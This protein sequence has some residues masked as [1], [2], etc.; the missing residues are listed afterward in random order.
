[1][2]K[3]YLILILLIGGLSFAQNK[4][5]SKYAETITTEDLKKHLEVLASDKY[6]GRETGEK[7][8]R[9]AAKYLKKVF[10]ELSLE[11][12][13]THRDPFFQEMKLSN[14]DCEEFTIKSGKTSL[15]NGDDFLYMDLMGGGFE[16]EAD[17]EVVFAGFGLESDYE[18]IDVNGKVVMYFT[19][20]PEDK[21]KDEEKIKKEGNSITLMLTDEKLG[22]AKK[23]GA[24]G[25][26]KIDR[27]EEAAKYLFKM[28][29][30]YIS[31]SRM[32]QYTKK[33]KKGQPE[34]NSSLMMLQS[35]V[36]KLLNLKEE[37]I[38]SVL[39]QINEGKNLAGKYKFDIHV[40]AK[41]NNKA[42][43]TENVVAYI[44]GCE[45]KD[46]LIIIEAHYDHLGKKGDKI[47]NG[48]DDN[49][50]GTVA[51]LEIAEAF[52][53]AK[54]NGVL[55][56]RSILFMPVTGEEKGL[57]GSAY[58]TNNPIFPLEN[59]VLTMNMDMLGRTDSTH[60]ENP[61]YVYVYCSDKRE[62]D[63]HNLMIDS[64]KSV[65]SNLAP[66]YKFKGES[67]GF[68]GSDHMSFEMKKVPVLYYYA[69]IHADYHKPTD[70]VEKI[71]F[72][73]FTNITRLVFSTAW[74]L[75]NRENININR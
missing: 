1:M 7:G 4:I 73:N 37:D 9:M 69:G 59:T 43:P 32:G 14:K 50:T 42:V 55:P 49:A 52:A 53:K 26:I 66:E 5:V 19:G 57:L 11:G 71:N 23:H 60:L 25:G 46:E 22:I 17:F 48:A 28:L 45:L 58:Y 21:N 27:D 38:S 64:E 68:G 35:S 29:G 30:P 67:Q 34:L 70:T 63:L 61:D 51:I 6:E 20:E 36:A 8:Q 39:E 12:P 2:K 56:K 62:S 24:V 10:K 47:Y 41:Y 72:K 75:A 54:A 33:V 65:S 74:E 18:N 31:G 44:E 3:I 15:I 40:K 16:G 13:S